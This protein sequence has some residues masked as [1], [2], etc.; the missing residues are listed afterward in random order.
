MAKG[1][2]L[3]I[4]D[5]NIWGPMEATDVDLA[6]S[7]SETPSVLMSALKWVAIGILALGFLYLILSI[8]RR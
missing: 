6:N 8:S 3:V 2:Y 1:D 7:D 5:E 4:A